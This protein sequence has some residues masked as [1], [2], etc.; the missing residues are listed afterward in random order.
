MN[1]AS[2]ADIAVL[3]N[4]VTRIDT[5]ISNMAEVSNNIG[6]LLAVHES[7]LDHIE[8]TN[9][10]VSFDVRELHSRITTMSKEILSKLDETED[11]FYLMLKEVSKTTKDQV[12]EIKKDFDQLEKRVLFVEKWKYYVIGGAI[13]LGW[14]LS[15]LPVATNLL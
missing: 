2:E 15:R 10:E 3:K 11:H 7:R 5:A 1:Q 13:A 4:V 12:D 6:K 9:N 14:A 8:K